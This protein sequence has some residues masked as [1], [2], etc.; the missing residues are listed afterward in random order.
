M[1]VLN[2]PDTFRTIDAVD[3]NPILVNSY[4]INS[5]ME[6]QARAKLVCIARF[7][8]PPI[9]GL[10]QDMSE[11]KEPPAIPDDYQNLPSK[12]VAPAQI[13][14]SSSL[15]AQPPSAGIGKS[16]AAPT[17]DGTGAPAPA[18]GPGGK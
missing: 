17:G 4:P 6:A 15:S 11:S 10:S 2:F 7:F 9:K 13:R 5:P 1:K 8:N 16:L 14:P 3:C 12:K 18:P